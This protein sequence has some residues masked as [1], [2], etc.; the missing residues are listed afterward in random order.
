MNKKVIGW[1]INQRS[2]MGQG[3]PQFVIDELIAQNADI[4]VLTEAYKDS[5]IEYFFCEMEKA[6]YSYAISQN[7]GMNEVCIL[8]KTS[9]YQMIS[10]D[11]SVI[12]RKDNN[13][14]NL[15]LVDLEDI[16]TKKILTVVGYRIRMADYAERV[17]ELEIVMDKVSGKETPVLIV[18][19]CNNLRRETVETTWNLNVVDDILAAND[20]IR[21]TPAGQSI[22][23]EKAQG[24]YAYE[25]A[26]DHIITRGLSVAL[27]AYDRSFV[28]RYPDAYPWGTDFQK[29]NEKTGRPES[30]A[31]GYPDHAIVKGYFR[32]SN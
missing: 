26:E 10:V 1:N 4:I 3:I 27:G 2:G 24:G 25:F 7:D 22:Y 28:Y 18:T 14:P 6:G 9:C 5:T 20:F 17:E 23:A 32:E 15:L 31:P 19:D 11:D 8:W 29:Y 16:A 13:N 12:S 30:I 21:H